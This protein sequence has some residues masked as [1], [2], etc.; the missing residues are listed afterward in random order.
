MASD[1]ALDHAAYNYVTS[2][3]FCFLTFMVRIPFRYEN[4]FLWDD[5]C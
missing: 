3:N 5:L 4:V 1:Y 2:E